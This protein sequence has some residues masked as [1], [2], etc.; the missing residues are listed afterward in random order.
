MQNNKKRIYSFGFLLTVLGIFLPWKVEGDFLF[1]RIRGVQ[2]FPGFEDNGG[3]V[4]LILSFLITLLYL[5]PRFIRKIPRKRLYLLCAVL[6][7]LAIYQITCII[8]DSARKI[9]I[10]GAPALQFGLILVLIGSCIQF[11]ILFDKQNR[12]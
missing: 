1:Q 10:V 7:F 2:F 6:P 3:L 12:T 5:F 9:A 8:V 11:V 4:I